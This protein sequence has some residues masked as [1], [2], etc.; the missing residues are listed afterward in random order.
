MHAFINEVDVNFEKFFTAVPSGVDN[1]LTSLAAEK[2]K[3]KYSYRRVVSLQAWQSELIEN[4]IENEAAD[5]FKEAQNDALTSHYLARQGAWRVSLMSLRSCIENVLW[6]IYYAEHPVELFQWKNGDHRLGF[7]ESIG[8]VAKHPAFKNISETL[9]GIAIIKGEFSTL[10]RAVHG[11]SKLFRMTKG[12]NIA[13]ENAAS[14]PDLNAWE[15]REKHTLVGLNRIF[16]TYF[17][18][19]LSGA[20]YPNLRKAI[21][22][23]IPNTKHAEIKQNLGIA[24]RQH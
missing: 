22:L 20:A 2:E 3:F 18:G 8:Y 4:L 7:T 15:T 11:S 1:A 17:R 12:G 19:H 16:M 24:L 13:V 9:S 5:F 6:G 14:L 23:T 10:S 21:S